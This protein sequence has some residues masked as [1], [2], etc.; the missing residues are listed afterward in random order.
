M[1]SDIEIAQSTELKHIRE[2]ANIANIPEDYLDY[3]GKYKAKID[4]KLLE[5]NKEKQGKLVLVTAIN[6]TPAGEGKTTT[7][8]GLADGLKK[9][10]KNVIVALREPS[11]GPVFGVKGGAA[12]G[13]YAQIA[14]MEDINLHF[15]GDFHAIGAANNLLAAMLDNHIF[16]GNSLGI[17]P[18]KITWRRAVDMNDRQLRNI[19]DGLGGGKNGVPRKDGFDITVASEIMAILCLSNSISDLKNRLSRIIVGYTF[20]GKPVT[21]GDLKAHGAMAAL[22]KEA[23]KPNLVQTLEGTPAIVHGGPFAN[24]AHGCNSVLATKMA[25]SLGDY[26]ITEAGFGADLGAEKFLDIK[27]RLAG[28]KPSCVVI[29]ATIRALKMHGG[30]EKAELVNENLEALKKGLPNLLR[31]ISNI[32]NVYKLPAVVAINKFETDTQNEIDLLTNEC[33]ALGAN[34]VLSDVWANGGNGGV[35]LAKEVINLCEKENDFT[36]SYESELSIKEKIN[37]VVTKVYGG[38]STVY[39]EEAEKEI[40][41]LEELGFG[42]CPVCIAKTQYSFSD[43]ATKLGAPE[44]FEVTVRNVKVS[45]G[46]GFIVVLTGA[47]LTMPGLPKI[48]AAEGIDVDDEGKITGLF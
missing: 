44:N 32:T 3:Y 11:L 10:N 13:G 40:A 26:A 17:D 27:C 5:K 33:K 36:F 45:S 23:I 38:K 15:T 12:G 31:H 21:A 41:K 48:P 46:A 34:V 29:V 25:M 18:T 28:L 37:A 47:I 43:D 9:L 4:L 20:E 42:N 6:P 30:M 19:E 7:T 16:Q 14:P 1:K 22:L 39:T 24:I 8:I 2:I 35:E